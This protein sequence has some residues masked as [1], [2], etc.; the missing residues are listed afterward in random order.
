MINYGIDTADF[1]NNSLHISGWVFLLNYTIEV[2]VD[3]K[4]IQNMSL[5][6]LFKLDK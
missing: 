1:D 2:L 4:I 6:N 3:N 5:E